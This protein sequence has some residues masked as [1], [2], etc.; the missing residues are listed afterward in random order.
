[1]RSIGAVSYSDH[2]FVGD[3]NEMTVRQPNNKLIARASDHQQTSAIPRM[4]RPQ[5]G[6]Q[7][8]K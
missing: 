2:D 8:K 4:V 5:R 7:K 3:L 6:V 1:V